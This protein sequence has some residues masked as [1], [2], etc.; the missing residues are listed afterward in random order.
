LQARHSTPWPFLDGKARL[1]ARGFTLIELLVVIFIMALLVALSVSSLRRAKGQAQSTVCQSNLR[2]ML[3]EFATYEV[4]NGQLPYS[5]NM[6]PRL[7]PPPGGLAGNA[8]RDSGDWWWF[9]FLGHP[10]P[11]PYISPKPSILYCPS[12]PLTEPSLKY[13]C[14]YGNYGVNWSLCRGSSPLPLFMEF[15]GK[16][17][18]LSHLIKASE[19][20]LIVDSGYALISWYH[21][22]ANPPSPMGNRHGC[23]TAYLPGLG[24]NHGRDLLPGQK[25]DALDG[26]HPN[27]TVNV[28]FADSHVERKIAEAL[29]VTK[30]EE[31]Y[32]NLHPLWKPNGPSG[33]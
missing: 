17:L 32:T 19:I 11:H 10:T 22:T 9:H 33:P 31:G 8:A 1:K 27:K 14:L 21:V 28:G 3:V 15:E 26:R 23:E 25:E 18:T 24:I 4:A 6:N 12:N 16:P 30:T 7:G 2:Q 20:L 13:N 29:L 5:S